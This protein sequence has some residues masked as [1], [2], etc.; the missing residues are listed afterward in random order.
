MIRRSRKYLALEALICGLM[1]AAILALDTGYRY[2][3]VDK[4]NALTSTAVLMVL[5]AV[6]AVG[7]LIDLIGTAI[8]KFSDSKS[9]AREVS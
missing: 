4:G 3:L 6:V 2:G 8:S 1:F 7:L 5:T 9:S